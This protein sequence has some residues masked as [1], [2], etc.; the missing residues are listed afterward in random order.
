MSNKAIHKKRQRSQILS[1]RQWGTERETTPL[2]N[3]HEE[4]SVYAVAFSRL[5]I[6]LTIVF[7]AMYVTSVVIR[8][9]IDGPKSYQFTMEVLGYLIVVTLLTFSALV[10][11]IVRQ[12]ALQRFGRHT[13]V[14][15]AVLD[16]YFSAHQP[17][18]TVLIPS[19]SE[20]TQ[21]IRKTVLSAALQEYPVMKVVLLLDDDPTKVRPEDVAR[22]EATRALGIEIEA[23]FSEPNKRFHETLLQ[24]EKTGLKNKTL[25]GG[26]C[27]ARDSS[28]LSLG[29]RMA[30]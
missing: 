26:G 8:Q 13:R 20:E 12:G 10:Y 14:P 29:S 24:F 19:Y 18:I 5:S 21:V 17:S 16:R 22:L 11:L 25:T 4:P 9:L 7:W 1:K 30:E 27:L 6:V 2:P 23:F 28:T 15:R 3:L